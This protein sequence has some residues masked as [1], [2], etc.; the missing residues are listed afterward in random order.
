MEPYSYFLPKS[1]QKHKGFQTNQVSVKRY[2]SVFSHRVNENIGQ[3]K[4]TD[5]GRSITFGR[6]DDSNFLFSTYQ[7]A[8]TEFTR[9]RYRRFSA[10]TDYDHSLY[11]CTDEICFMFKLR[12]TEGV[13]CTKID[14]SCIN[15]DDS[16]NS[17]LQKNIAVLQYHHIFNQFSCSLSDVERKIVIVTGRDLDSYGT[18]LEMVDN[19]MDILTYTIGSSSIVT[20]E[21]K[22][23]KNLT[24]ACKLYDVDR[25]FFSLCGS[26]LFFVFGKSFVVYSTS[27]DLFGD[28]FEL[29]ESEKFHMTRYCFYVHNKYTGNML[30]MCQY[31]GFIYTIREKNLVLELLNERSIYLSDFGLDNEWYLFMH[32]DYFDAILIYFTAGDDLLILD[33]FKRGVVGKFKPPK[34]HYILDVKTNWSGE[35]VFVFL[36]RDDIENMKQLQLNILFISKKNSL[37]DIAKL[38]VLQTFSIQQ[39]K[40][41]EL[42]ANLKVEMQLF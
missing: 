11:C 25:I 37:K 20:M 1:Y 39:L 17:I 16:G 28:I 21:P 8:N 5:N 35:E 13:S 40:D 30:I 6:R 36:G 15:F 22:I 10:V 3:R 7:V 18:A 23:R 33:Y 9:S 12:K 27:L 31:D 26:K 14:I 38:K 2:S 19:Y 34:R 4:L 42:P 24:G 29:D 32:I 41:L